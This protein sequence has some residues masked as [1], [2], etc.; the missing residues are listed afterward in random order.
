MALRGLTTQTMVTVSARWL[1]PNQER[2]ILQ[3][4]PLSRA[5]LTHL[6]TAHA[7]L[8]EFQRRSTTNEETLQKLSERLAVLDDRHDRILRGAHGMLTSLA[9]LA[10]TDE[11]AAYYLDLRDKLFPDGLRGVS[12]SYVDQAGEVM[13]L[14]GRL[15]DQSAFALRSIL[16]PNGSLYGHVQTL[17]DIGREMGRLEAERTKLGRG[18]EQTTRADVARARNEWI[19]VVTALRASVA[20]DSVS[21]EDLDRIFRH[22]DEAEAKADRRTL[23][24]KATEAPTGSEDSPPSTSR[25]ESN[26]TEQVPDSVA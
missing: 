1:D 7:R 17:I 6:S 23:S 5:L 4:Y 2:P 21:A 19:R 22:L 18:S 20:L 11:R 16:T 25:C 9:A 14:E 24:S 13:L 3:R 10:D 26:R 15:D 8:I 12:R